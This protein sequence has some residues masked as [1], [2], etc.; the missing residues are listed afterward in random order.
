MIVEI[1]DKTITKETWIRK[2]FK[3][4]RNEKNTL[5]FWDGITWFIYPLNRYHIEIKDVKQ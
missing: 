1:T 3:F 2:D 4:M 5:A